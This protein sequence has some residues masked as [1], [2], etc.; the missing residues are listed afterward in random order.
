ME[1]I[2]CV[3]PLTILPPATHT[4][5]NNIRI[6]NIF[7]IFLPRGTLV[8]ILTYLLFYLLN[9]LLNYLLTYLLTYLFTYLITYLLRISD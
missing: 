7:V 4:L 2:Y 6:G 3:F 9:Y 5:P 8:K 1:L